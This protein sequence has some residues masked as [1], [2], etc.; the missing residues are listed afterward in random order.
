MQVSNSLSNAWGGSIVSSRSNKMSPYTAMYCE[1][2][3]GGV[4]TT[5]YIVVDGNGDGIGD[6]ECLNGEVCTLLN[7]ADEVVPTLMVS[8]G[9]IIAWLCHYCQ[10]IDRFYIL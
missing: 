5:G 2:C 10:N 9:Y 8:C 4:A 6:A 7:L 3:T 1:N